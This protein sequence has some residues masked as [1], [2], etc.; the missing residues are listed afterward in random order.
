ML[1]ASA[2]WTAPSGRFSLMVW[3]R[4]LLN[5]HVITQAPTQSFGYV[6]TYGSPPRTYGVTA[7]V[8]F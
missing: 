3:G 8:N 7:R 4:N 6:A 2:K 5:E 1:N